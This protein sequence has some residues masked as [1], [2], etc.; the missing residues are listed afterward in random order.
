MNMVTLFGKL[1]EHELKLGRL[2]EE[3]NGEKRHTIALKFATKTAAKSSSRE[4]N[5]RDDQ[6]IENYDSEAINLMV[7]WFSKFLK[8]TNK[9]NNVFA[10]NRRSFR[11]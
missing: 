7:K 9:I 4:T 11:K 3:E 6:T 2:K 5:S 8:Y 1:R 10:R